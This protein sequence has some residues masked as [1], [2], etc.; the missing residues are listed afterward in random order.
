MC[1]CEGEWT[2]MV[3]IR[4]W[5]KILAVGKAC[6]AI[7]WPT[8]GFKGKKR[9]LWVLKRADLTFCIRNT[10]LQ[11]IS[12]ES[13]WKQML[14]SCMSIRGLVTERF[15]H[16]IHYG[17]TQCYQHQENL[18]LR[19]VV[20]SSQPLSFWISNINQ[21]GPKQNSAL[22]KA[23]NLLLTSLW[24]IILCEYHILHVEGCVCVCSDLLYHLLAIANAWHYHVS[25]IGQVHHKCNLLLSLHHS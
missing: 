19:R 22:S 14:F 21:T 3:E 2:V 5:K 10:P 6:V 9:L 16:I 20:Y 1:E 8:S 23:F 24:H 15:L 12:L 25:S 4:T 13:S 11:V 17:P 7:F 18:A